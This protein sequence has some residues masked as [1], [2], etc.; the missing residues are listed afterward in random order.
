LWKDYG[1]QVWDALPDVRHNSEYCRNTTHYDHE[2]EY[3]G[4]ILT[5]GSSRAGLDRYVDLNLNNLKSYSKTVEFRL[6][7]AYSDN[8]DGYTPSDTDC[9]VPL[10][11]EEQLLACVSVSREFVRAAITNDTD[12]LENAI[13]TLE[14][15]F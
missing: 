10:I 7:P 12:E 11:T 5:T 4:N 14:R 3:Y 13:V 2:V 1:P 6:F 9:D 8:P 15:T